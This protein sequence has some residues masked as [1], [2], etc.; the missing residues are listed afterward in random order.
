MDLSDM[1]DLSDDEIDWVGQISVDEDYGEQENTFPVFETNYSNQEEAEVEE[2][3]P[4]VKKTKW[5]V[6]FNNEWSKTYSWIVRG[7]DIS[8]AKCTVCESQ[9]T[10][11]HGGENDIIKH[12][13]TEKHKK[14]MTKGSQEKKID[15]FFSKNNLDTDLTAQ[16]ECAFV[17]HSIKHAHSYLSADCAGKLFSRIFQDS[18]IAKSYSCGRTKATKL[19]TN[20]LGPESKH[21]ILNDLANNQPFCIATD[22]SN[23]GNVKTFPLVVRYFKKEIGV[24]TKLLKFYSAISEKSEAIANSLVESLTEA[25]LNILNVTA[26]CADNASVNFGKKQSVITELNKLNQNIVPVGC[27]C[28]IIHNAGKH[29]QGALKYDVESIVI[30]CYNEFSSSTKKVNELKDFLF[31]V[32]K[33][34]PIY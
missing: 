7:K 21:I 32:K 19:V 8:Q 28:H 11:N 13:K 22:A 27:V 17:F 26:Y 9:F 15:N 1:S 31:F 24:C 12:M 5:N 30:K 33:N 10:I 2:A 4:S 14:N 29:G 3:G 23:K 25:G 18:K 34:G 6:K 16:A 20:I